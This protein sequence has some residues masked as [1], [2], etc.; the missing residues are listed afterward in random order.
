M[1]FDEALLFRMPLYEMSF[2]ETIS[3]DQTLFPSKKPLL[4]CNF[5]VHFCS[6]DFIMK[7]ASDF[8]VLRLCFCTRKFPLSAS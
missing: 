4:M 5:N 2:D 3:L 1:S 8:F 6:L 7:F